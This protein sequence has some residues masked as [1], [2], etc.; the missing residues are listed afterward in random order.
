MHRE[1]FQEQLRKSFIGYAGILVAAMLVL[2]LGSC[3]V[4][5]Y[6][7]VV[8]GNRNDNDQITQ[9]LTGQMAS[10][11]QGLAEFSRSDVLL[12]A[13][14]QE[15]GAS[16][17]EANRCLYAFANAQTMRPYFVL[18]DKA[19]KVVCSNF[20][21]S[22]QNIFS[23]SLFATGSITRMWQEPEQVIQSVFTARVSS[24]QT[25]CYSLSKALVDVDGEIA[26]YLLFNIRQESFEALAEGR[27]SDVLLADKY[28]NVIYSTL[29]LPKD[30]SDKLPSGKYTLSAPRDHMLD[31]GDNHYYVTE[32]TWEG[33]ALQ[34]YTLTYMNTHTRMLWFG[35]GLF[36]F[37]LVILVGMI[38][39]LTGAFSRKNAMELSELKYAVEQLEQN[40]GVE[41]LPAQCSEETQALYMHFRTLIRHNNALIDRRRQM[42]IKQLESQFN[43]HFVYNIMETIR[44]QMGQ[45]AKAA[46]RMLLSFAALMRYS[47]NYGSSKVPLETDVEYINDYLLLQKVRFNNCLRYSFSIPEELLDCQIPKL[48]LQPVIENSIKHGYQS[49]KTLDISITAEKVGTDLCFTVRDNGAGMSRERLEGIRELLRQEPEE[50]SAAHVGLYN[51]HKVVSLTYGPP[52]G[53]EVDSVP[54]VGTTVVIHMPYEME[55]EEC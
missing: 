6:V 47:I 23:G 38:W 7:V 35:V 4:N 32:S 9:A 49:G 43:P 51:A 10:Y 3:L 54:D 53:L 12:R 29:K 50:V 21:Y 30:P 11:A 25:C 17:T 40:G 16:R 8:Q 15:D 45:D 13:V 2:Y 46:S 34:L 31:F 14:S 1:K 44:Y 19:G 26:G 24:E 33:A 55:G 27:S 22:N 18:M 42:E 41:D 39:V 48:L 28:G 20:S 5:Y 52:Y 36:F 37:L